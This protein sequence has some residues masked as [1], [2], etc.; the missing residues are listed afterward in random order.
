M[1]QIKLTPPAEADLLDI[2]RY[3]HADNPAAADH[4]LDA[5]DQC[6]QHLAAFPRAGKPW[7]SSNRLLTDVR[8]IPL[9]HFKN[10]LV[11]YRSTP[12]DL[13]IISIVHAAR[14]LPAVLDEMPS[15]SI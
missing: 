2:H 9:P 6:F 4:V 5:A 12:A 1:K 10:Y 7:A 8:L 3:I 11:F 15:G 14:D 13:L